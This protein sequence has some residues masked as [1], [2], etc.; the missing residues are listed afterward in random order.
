MAKLNFKL[1]SFETLDAIDLALEEKNLKENG[2]SAGYCSSSNIGHDCFRYLWYS[3]RWASKTVLSGKTLRT[4]SKGHV[5]EAQMAERLR[6]VPN[7]EL[8]TIDPETGQQFLRTFYGGH[9]KCYLDGI[10][11]GLLEAP[12]TV[13]T[14]EHKE[15]GHKKFTQLKNLLEKHDE[16]DVLKIWNPVYYAQ[17]VIGMDLFGIKRS[18]MTVAT[19]GGSDWLSIRTNENPAYA[20]ELIKRAKQIFELEKPPARVSDNP[21]FF[22]CKWCEHN[23][24][25]H[26]DDPEENPIDMNCRTCCHSTIREDGHWVCESDRRQQLIIKREDQNL[27]CGEHLINT[28]L[29]NIGKRQAYKDA[30]DNYYQIEYTRKDGVHFVNEWG[31]GKV[32]KIGTKI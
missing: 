9:F 28:N 3:F 18:F 5:G 12:K 1:S 22:Q 7:I 24:I 4:F 17:V 8:E 20:K 31:T 21:E 13:H 16:K 30:Q 32:K 2:K 27:A 14:W 6:L 23:K 29:I 26:F 25:C 11:S 15:P 19:D 10:I